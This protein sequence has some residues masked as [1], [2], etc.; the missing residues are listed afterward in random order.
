MTQL[1]PEAKMADSPRL[2]P[3]LLLPSS[4]HECVWLV[5]DTVSLKGHWQ[6]SLAPHMTS[7]M[8]PVAEMPSS[9]E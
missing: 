8:A 9:D 5:L 6:A 4:D 3:V 7:Q 2:S 1:D